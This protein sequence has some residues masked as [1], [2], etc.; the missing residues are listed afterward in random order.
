MQQQQRAPENTDT[1]RETVNSPPRRRNT[2]LRSG[3]DTTRRRSRARR[4]TSSQITQPAVVEVRILQVPQSIT[5]REPIMPSEQPARERS[6]PKQSIEGNFSNSSKNIT[7]H[8]TVLE[9]CCTDSAQ[10]LCRSSIDLNECLNNTYGA[11]SWE[12]YGNAFEST[13]DVQ[14]VNGHILEGRLKDG[15]GGWNTSRIDLDERITNVNGCLVFTGD[16]NGEIEGIR[17]F[18]QPADRG[19]TNLHDQVQEQVA[20]SSSNIVIEADNQIQRGSYAQHTSP[21]CSM[22]IDTVGTVS[23]GQRLDVHTTQS[24]LPDNNHSHSG[25]KDQS[26]TTQH[27]EVELTTMRSCTGYGSTRRR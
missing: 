16:V 21:S 5:P 4:R 26:R 2:G 12:R 25:Q 6:P 1:I 22:V 7:L 20:I 27:A 19:D 10:R 9:V 23:A 14:L 13:A 3:R 15:R 8:G 17:T 24:P 18:V 11:F